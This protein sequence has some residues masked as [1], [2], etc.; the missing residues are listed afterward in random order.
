[1]I[2]CDIITVHLRNV[3]KYVYFYCKGVAN[4]IG[5]TTPLLKEI[6]GEG[7]CCLAVSRVNTYIGL[8]ASGAGRGPAGQSLE[9]N[10]IL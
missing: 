1:M 8:M 10:N 6:G 9:Y 4:H 3:T 5:N 2:K 7:S